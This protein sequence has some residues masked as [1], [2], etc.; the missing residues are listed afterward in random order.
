MRTWQQPFDQPTA[1]PPNPAISS[2]FSGWVPG[3]PG[4]VSAGRISPQG[5]IYRPT[6]LPPAN[7]THDPPLRPVVISTGGAPLEFNAAVLPGGGSPPPSGTPAIVPPQ[8]QPPQMST[9]VRG[10]V[11]GRATLTVTFA[12]DEAVKRWL[13]GQSPETALVFAARAA[14]RIV[15]TITFESW[16]GSGRKTTR[17]IVLRVFRAVAAA[18]AVAAFPGQRDL[19]RDTAR[20]ALFGL[21][22]V[23]ARI[24]QPID[25][26]VAQTS[27]LA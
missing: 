24:I 4:P 25:P 14:L 9:G 27:V 19:L 20:A 2:S 26:L 3:P 10:A 1:R 6:D 21:G 11:Q 18:W 12:D 8:E 17:E 13:N 5:N 7:S 16:P 22:D 15:P 23:L